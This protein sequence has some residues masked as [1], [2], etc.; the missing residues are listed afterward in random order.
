MLEHKYRMQIAYDGTAY[1][2]WQIQP[3]GQSIQ[4]LIEQA[5]QKILKEPTRLIGAGRTDAGVHAKGQEAHFTFPSELICS[6]LHYR[7]NGLLPRDIRIQD[8]FRTEE[9]F[10]AQYSACSKEY[11]YNIWLEK[12]IDPFQR[13]YRHHFHDSR[14]QL[15]LLQ[16]GIQ[17]FIGRHDFTSFANV[18]GA[19]S[20]NIRTIFE[21][22]LHHQEG[23]IRLE[24]KGDGFLYKMVRNIVGTLLDIATAKISVSDINTLFNSRDRRAAGPAAPAKGLFLMKVNYPDCFLKNSAK[25]EKWSKLFPISADKA[26]TSELLT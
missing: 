5:L 22:G 11:H 21:I 7:L 8:I 15:P 13:L 25:E 12:V 23:G 1:C 18:G 10:H 24:F 6:Q 17:T 20:S 2:G 3:N 14:F 9:N 26:A 16:A 19:M 4:E